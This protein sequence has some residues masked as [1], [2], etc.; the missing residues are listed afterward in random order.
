MLAAGQG[1]NVSELPVR[2]VV[3]AG[4]LRTGSFNRR[5][6][7]AAAAVAAAR[8]AEVR[9]VN[10]GDWPLPIYDGDL[11]AG[12]GVPEPAVQLKELF[13]DHDGFIVASPEYNGSFSPLLK[14]VI[15]W[16]SR[17]GTD[18]A[19][20][21]PYRGKVAGLLAASPGRLGGLRGLVDVRRVLSGIGVHV[22]PAEFALNGAGTAF[23]ADGE[24]LDSAHRQG[25]ARVV[26]QV[27]RTAARLRA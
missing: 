11:E 21:L 17:Q 7:R 22:V 27:I 14:N 24:L 9:E 1:E 23:G 19:P 8:G 20:M 12:S 5:L 16:M 6:A 25:V 18:P 3:F 10:L 13:A 15:D 4:S 2:L 26:D